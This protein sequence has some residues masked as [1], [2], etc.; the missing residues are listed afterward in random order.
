MYNTIKKHR[1]EQKGEHSRFERL[2]S[3][4]KTE[5]RV[6]HRER[7]YVALHRDFLCLHFA[8]K[9]KNKFAGTLNLV[10]PCW[11]TEKRQNYKAQVKV[12][13]S[14]ILS[15]ILVKCAELEKQKE[16]FSWNSISSSQN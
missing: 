11:K 7:R 8:Y 16:H 13:T 9:K 3:F 12:W 6:C 10:T 2:Y 15:T 5:N 1:R 4:G 14:A